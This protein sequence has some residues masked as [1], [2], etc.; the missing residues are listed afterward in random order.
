MVWKRHQQK[1]RLCGQNAARSL[2]P[3]VTNT[4][5]LEGTLAATLPGTLPSDVLGLIAAHAAPDNAASQQHTAD[6]RVQ[7][8]VL[9]ELHLGRPIMQGRPT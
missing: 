5:Q 7:P 9:Q 8:R 1:S 3:A 4:V 6:A 2:P